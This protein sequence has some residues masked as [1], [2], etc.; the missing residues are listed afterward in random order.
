M[1]ETRYGVCAWCDRLGDL[2]LH[3]TNKKELRWICVTFD[4]DRNLCREGDAEELAAWQAGKKDK[5]DKKFSSETA[6]D[7]SEE[8]FNTLEDI[9]KQFLGFMGNT[10]RRVLRDAY[11][12]GVKHG[13]SKGKGSSSSRARPY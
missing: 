7:E 13:K 9:E 6:K 8:E 12:L 4:G 11:D 5:K 3:K 10:M 2:K 1:T